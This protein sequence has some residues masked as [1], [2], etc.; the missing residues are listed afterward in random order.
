MQPYR[1]GADDEINGRGISHF[2]IGNVYDYVAVY[3]T[4]IG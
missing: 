3:I 2:Y 4:E 1:D